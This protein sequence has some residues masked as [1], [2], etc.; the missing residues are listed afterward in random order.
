MVTD[1]FLYLKTIPRMWPT[2]RPDDGGSKDLWNAGKLLPY[3]MALQ[4]RRQPSSI[5]NSNHIRNIVTFLRYSIFEQRNF[6]PTD[7]SNVSEQKSMTDKLSLG[8]ILHLLA[9]Q[10]FWEQIKC[11]GPLFTIIYILLY[12]VLEVEKKRQRE[13]RKKNSNFIIL[14]SFIFCY[15]TLIT[16][17]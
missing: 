3:Y 6:W 4:P 5:K 15:N 14:H 17:S 8:N 10:C 13:R 16:K 2:H 7:V 1:W 9:Q 12:P 11:S